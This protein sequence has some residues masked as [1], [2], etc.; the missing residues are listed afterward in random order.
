ML[1]EKKH[2]RRFGNYCLSTLLVSALL[3]FFDV[4]LLSNCNYK[5]ILLGQVEIIGSS[6]QC[7]EGY[8]VTFKDFDH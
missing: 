5:C 3:R 1:T 6:L 4:N 8:N 7:F 2:T